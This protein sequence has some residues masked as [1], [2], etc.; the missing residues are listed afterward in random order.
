MSS[1]NKSESSPSDGSALRS[2]FCCIH[3][4]P[5]EEET[6]FRSYVQNYLSPRK[7]RF[8]SCLMALLWCSQTINNV[9]VIHNNTTL[10]THV[11]P[12]PPDNYRGVYVAISASWVLHIPV[13]AFVLTECA[14]LHFILR[15]SVYLCAIVYAVVVQGIM[16]LDGEFVH[17]LWMLVALVVCLSFTFKQMIPYLS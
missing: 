14:T 12:T 1:N 4:F 6:K 15:V 2:S 9:V 5:T 8:L 16:G 17:D 3:E 10:P 13:L 7:V 11:H